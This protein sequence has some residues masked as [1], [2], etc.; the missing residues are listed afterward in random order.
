MNDRPAVTEDVLRAL[1]EGR[2]DDAL[3][4]ATGAGEDPW[5]LVLASFAAFVTTDFPAAVVFAD[6]ALATAPDPV[7]R[8]AA[9][10]VRGFASAGWWPPHGAAWDAPDGGDP[11]PAALALLP[12]LEDS[13]EA[14]VARYLVAEGALACGRLGLAAEAVGFSGALP[15]WDGHPFPALVRIMR[16]RLLA[17]RGRIAEADALLRADSGQHGMLV[18][19][20]LASTATLVRGNAADRAETRA[21]AD[22]I[23][24]SDL[25]LDDYLSG[26]SR[27]LVAFGLLAI[28][29][30]ARAARFILIAGRD[31]EL[32]ATSILDRALG[33][34]TLVALAAADGDLDAAEA[35]AERAAPL[36]RTPIAAATVARLDSRVALLAGRVRD[37]VEAADLA[38]ALARAEGRVVEAVEGE[39]VGSRARVAASEAGIAVSRLEAAVAE[40]DHTGYLAV[41]VSAARALRPSGR[42][43]RPV[44][45]TGWAGLSSRER[46]VA[47]LVA[48][49][50]SNASIA[51]TLHLSGH[52]VRAHVS[53]VLAA[54]GAASRIAV[55]QA[56]A[57][58][59]PIAGAAVSLTPRQR[60]VVHG[61]LRGL[62]NAAIAGELGISTKTVEKHLADVRARWGVTTRAELARLARVSFAE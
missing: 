14:E 46:E 61:V 3:A 28:G 39:I 10:G 33:L 58:R 12:A 38:V 18:E 4:V 16:V 31:E 26:G 29:D 23:E 25:P 57:D 20:L 8:V 54:F 19:L 48:E 55:V 15:Q 34:E 53:R 43:L 44:S 21:L 7:T 9:L 27:L 30:V 41:R 2:S 36:R 37:A 6:R 11:L 24:A 51:R 1:L 17:F 5:F 35:W 62:G 49:G 32:S 45:G 13:R 52:T 50:A 47:L 56:L 59:A 40:A 42:R 22:R 60:A